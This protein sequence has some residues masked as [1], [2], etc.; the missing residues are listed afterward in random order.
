MTVNIKGIKFNKLT[1]IKFVRRDKNY[2]QYWLFKCDCGKEKTISKSAVMSGHTISCGCFLNSKEMKK[3]RSN[4]HKTHGMRNTRIYSTWKNMLGRIRCKTNQSYLLYGG[5]GI[6]VCERW[7]KFE[8]F[9]E[10]MKNTYKSNLTIDRIDNNK[11][12]N[13]KN[14]KWATIAE[15]NRNKSNIIKYKGEIAKNA[16]IRL[17]GNLGLV[18]RRILSGWSIK[19]AFCTKLRYLSK[20]CK[21]KTPDQFIKI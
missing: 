15:Q 6:T 1:G 21:Q 3:I 13:K 4:S 17:G 9:F 7:N 16:S 8:N 19:K 10:D 18:S 14:C 12:Y 2:N 11:G 20:S 5:R